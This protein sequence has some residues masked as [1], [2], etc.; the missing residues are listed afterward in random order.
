ML[1]LDDAKYTHAR[2]RTHTHT[3]TPAAAAA[4]WAEGQAPSFHEYSLDYFFLM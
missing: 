3:H 4:N 1:F 2:A